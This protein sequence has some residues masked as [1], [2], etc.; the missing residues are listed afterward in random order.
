M[1][2]EFINRKLAAHIGKYD[3]LFGRLCA[4]FHCI[5]HALDSYLPA[6]VTEDTASRVAEFMREFLLPHAFAFYGG[7]LK[8][9]DDTTGSRLRW[10]L[11]AHQKLRMT[12]RDVQRGD[13]TMRKLERRDTETVFEQLEALGWLTRTPGPRLIDPPHWIVNPV[14]HRRFA[15][16]GGRKPNGGSANGQLSVFPRTLSKHDVQQ[17]NRVIDEVANNLIEEAACVIAR[18][19]D[20]KA[21]VELMQDL[22]VGHWLVMPCVSELL[23]VIPSRSP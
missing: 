13:R 15:E 1:H 17:H 19:Q 18:A 2:F 5:E 16:R 11:L 14:V 22:P 8:F 9:A 12:N 4:L 20:L 23:K 6:V 21:Y 10:L 7:V 3:G